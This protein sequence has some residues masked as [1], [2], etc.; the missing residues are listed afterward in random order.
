MWTDFHVR[1]EE[2]IVVA[3]HPGIFSHS[4]SSS[5]F[6]KRMRQAKIWL[7]PN[8]NQVVFFYLDLAFA[9]VSTFLLFAETWDMDNECKYLTAKQKKPLKKE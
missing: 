1:G 9:H 2:E 3:W 6:G 8:A 7:L 5:V 4:P